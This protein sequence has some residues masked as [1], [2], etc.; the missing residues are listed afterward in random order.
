MEPKTP[1]RNGQLLYTLWEFIDAMQPQALLFC[2]AV[3]DFL[4]G[5]H[6][7]DPSRLK[8]TAVYIEYEGFLL[9]PLPERHDVISSALRWIRSVLGLVIPDVLLAGP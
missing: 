9:G 5:A 8:L 6:M 3:V 7:R 4:T 1:P 2:G